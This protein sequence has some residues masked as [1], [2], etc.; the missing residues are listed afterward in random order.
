MGTDNQLG[1]FCQDLGF[2]RARASA[3]GVALLEALE[4]LSGEAADGRIDSAWSARLVHLCRQ[5][6]IPEATAERAWQPTV[7]G[8]GALLPTGSGIPSADRYRC[9]RAV[10]SRYEL[11]QPGGPE[12]VCGLRGETLSLVDPA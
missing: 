12:P 3:A 6:G 11:R 2:L 4:R 5:L 8:P 1:R 10:C 7:G 9:P